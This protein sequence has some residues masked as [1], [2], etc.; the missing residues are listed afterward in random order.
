LQQ[1]AVLYPGLSGHTGHEIAAKQM[2]GFGGMV[3]FELVNESKVINAR[4]FSFFFWYRGMSHH[5]WN[6]N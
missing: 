6:L 3:A 4:R 5:R 1:P 2:R